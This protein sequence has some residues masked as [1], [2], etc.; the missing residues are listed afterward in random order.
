MT[1]SLRYDKE[2]TLMTTAKDIYYYLANE[3][4]SGII[5]RKADSVASC[6]E[7]IAVD[8]IMKGEY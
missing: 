4:I 8:M 3:C 7:G 6:M 5:K 1:A 2:V